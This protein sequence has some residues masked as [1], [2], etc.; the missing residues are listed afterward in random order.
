[1]HGIMLDLHI[2]LGIRGL[3]FGTV[4]VKT[5]TKCGPFHK[6]GPRKEIKPFFLTYIYISI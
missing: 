6:F 5:K 2:G 1:M 4:K 3:E